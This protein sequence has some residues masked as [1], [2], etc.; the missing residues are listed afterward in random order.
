MVSKGQS[1]ILLALVTSVVRGFTPSSGMGVTAAKPNVVP[2]QYIVETSSH[3]VVSQ[4]EG[5]GGQVSCQ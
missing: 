4:L 1:A 2:N 5:G 3:S